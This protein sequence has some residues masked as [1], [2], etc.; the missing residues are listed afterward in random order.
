MQSSCDVDFGG[1]AFVDGAVEASGK[2]RA[3]D[4]QARIR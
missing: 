4:M 2:P 1:F 3:G